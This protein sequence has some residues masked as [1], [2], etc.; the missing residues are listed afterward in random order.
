M[1][2]EVKEVLGVGWEGGH[3]TE[4]GEVREMEGVEMVG[5]AGERVKEDEEEKEEVLVEA[6]CRVGD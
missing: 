3:C 5:E 4:E 2:G 1:V 6:H